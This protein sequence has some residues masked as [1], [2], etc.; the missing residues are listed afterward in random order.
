MATAL[1]STS[2]LLLEAKN[3]HIKDEGIEIAG[4]TYK[5]LE[6]EENGRI[7]NIS[8]NAANIS[9]Y[10][11]S[12]ITKIK[13]ILKDIISSSSIEAR[14]LES[15]SWSIDYKDIPTAGKVSR[16]INK[17]SCFCPLAP[18]REKV[19]FQEEPKSGIRYPEFQATSDFPADAEKS[20][21]GAFTNLMQLIEPKSAS[22]QPFKS[23]HDDSTTSSS[24]S[25]STSSSSSSCHGLSNPASLGRSEDAENEEDEAL[26]NMMS[27]EMQFNS[28]ASS[29][30]GQSS[31]LKTAPSAAPI[32][33][34]ANIPN[35]TNQAATGPLIQLQ[36]SSAATT[37]SSSSSS[38][39]SSS[40]TQP[41]MTSSSSSSS[42]SLFGSQPFEASRPL[43]ASAVSRST[44]A[45]LPTPGSS[46]YFPT[47][48]DPDS[49]KPEM[50][51]SPRKKQN[52]PELTRNFIK[53]E[54]LK[55]N[56]AVKKNNTSSKATKAAAK[57]LYS[58]QCSSDSD[59]DSGNESDGPLKM[60]Q[61]A[62]NHSYLSSDKSSSKSDS[63]SDSDSESDNESDGS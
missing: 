58:D 9:L 3:I 4:A 11:K 10:S 28:S 35:L 6:I 44:I 37:T 5:S 53:E 43:E 17:V 60:V 26:D 51:N 19:L 49:I 2:S 21:A 59:N 42:S 23:P 38:S 45:H 31:S 55:K 20:F 18:A 14:D 12:T 40:L 34:A 46:V 54:R 24:A 63:K 62:H 39:S 50:P 61:K 30:S 22:G 32:P 36:A 7:R 52:I 8:L 27:G 33:Q 29:S 25:Y 47:D 13:S 57:D 15:Y 41:S 48:S 1:P 16:A 56:G